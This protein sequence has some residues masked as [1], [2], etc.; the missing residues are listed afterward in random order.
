MKL[1]SP[2]NDFV[3][4]RIFGDRAICYANCL[5]VLAMPNL[6]AYGVEF[7]GKQPARCIQPARY[8]RETPGR[9]PK[10]FVPPPAK[11]AY[12]T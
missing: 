7:R 11:P 8:R 5:G 3:F 6:H 2:V 4:K 1:L 10:G 9:I 12:W